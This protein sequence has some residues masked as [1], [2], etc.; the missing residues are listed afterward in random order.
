MN[1]YYFNDPDF[2]K[3]D[4]YKDFIKENPS[5][6]FLRIRAYSANEA[7]PVEG[8]KIRIKTDYKDIFG[9]PADV[10]AA[11]SEDSNSN[12]LGV[13]SGCTIPY[14]K[15]AN[16]NYISLDIKFNADNSSHKMLMKMDE[17]MLDDSPLSN[18][19][20][21][22]L[23][24]V[25]SNPFEIYLEGYT[26]E[27]LNDKTAK[28]RMT[29]KVLQDEI[30]KVLNYKGIRTALTNRVD[31]EYH[32]LVDTFESYLEKGCKSRLISLAKEKD[33]TFA[34]LNFPKMSAF[35]SDPSYRNETTGVFDIKK[36]ADKIKF[37]LPSEVNGASWGGFFTQLTFS[38]GTLKCGNA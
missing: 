14:F 25:K 18:S 16:G 24:N 35:V 20:Y 11:M 15:D 2:M 32:Y 6:G 17:K 37:D 3:S 10:L 5:T 4:L 26:Y 30:F 21:I 12:F 22:S 33:N 31:I 28:K 27:T 29:G 38:D 9:E 19:N 34:I 13:Y 7:L 1:T 23:K 36:V 8:I